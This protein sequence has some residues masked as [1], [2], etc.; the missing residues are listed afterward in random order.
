MRH[1]L[2][3]QI[4]IRTVW[5][6]HDPDRP[7][8]P[9]RLVEL[10]THVRSRGSLRA[11]CDDV[12]MSYRHAW[13]L[14]RQGEAH[15]DTP[16]LHQTRFR[17][18]TLTKLGE[19]L[20][21]ADQRI[22]ARLAPV[23][24]SLASELATEIARAITG[25]PAGLRLY[26]S[27][28][29]AIEMLVAAL[30]QTGLAVEHRYVSSVEAAA[31]LHDRACDV[32]AFHIPEGPLQVSALARYA[33][34]L[35]GEDLQVV[36]VATR[37]QG[38]MVAPG[39]PKKVYD[40]SDLTRPGVRFINR[41]AGSGTRFLLEGLLAARNVAAADIA[42]FEQGEFTHAAVAAHVAS[43]MADAGFGLETPARRLKLD[44]VP[45]ATERYILVGTSGTLSGEA[46]RTALSLMRDAVFRD[47]VDALPGYDAQHTGRVQPLAEAFD[48]RS[49]DPA[50]PAG[51]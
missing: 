24:D 40:V 13:N 51:T 31:A 28:G 39:N 15:F 5:T 44:F 37:H 18:S 30:T 49:A 50:R 10:L 29:F 23:L 47:A 2:A 8:I 4:S 32:A 25:E 41:Q 12:D 42:G 38:L 21:W 20:V 11:A 6:L 7:P 36:D 17:G 34:W 14:V 22:T 9:A 46:M 43:G 45:L 48:V 1:R 33:R 26:A 16:L 35:D 19:A 27:H 3:K